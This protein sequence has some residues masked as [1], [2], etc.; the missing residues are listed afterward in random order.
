MVNKAPYAYR[1]TPQARP[2]AIAKNIYPMSLG[3]PGALL[4]LIIDSVPARLNALA[5]LL[6]TNN[7]ITDNIV[8]SIISVIENPDVY[9]PCLYVFIYVT[10]IIIPNKSDV[11]SVIIDVLI[12]S[13]PSVIA[14]LK[15]VSS[16]FVC[17]RFRVI[18]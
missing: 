7:I 17:P 3:S 2:A 10:L 5:T 18:N 4:N 13:V 16:I 15:M 11:A 6:P 9:V 14:E 1:P 8:G 12:V